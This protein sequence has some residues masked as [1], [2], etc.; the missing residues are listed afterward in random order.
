MGFE[1]FLSDPI[2]GAGRVP[3][4]TAYA[5]KQTPNADVFGISEYNPD[6]HAVPVSILGNGI[7]GFLAYYARFSV[8]H[9]LYTSE[10][11]N[12]NLWQI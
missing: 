9:T 1:V 12:V 4:N 7:L 10:T 11:K 3:F 6:P 8:F 5:N 2:K